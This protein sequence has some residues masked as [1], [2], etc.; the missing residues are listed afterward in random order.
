MRSPP[1]DLTTA[2]GA[3]LHYAEFRDIEEG[4]DFGTI[5]VL[6]AA[7]SSEIAVIADNIDGVTSDWEQAREALPPEALGKVIR[8]EFRFTSDDISNFAGWYIDDPQV[9]VP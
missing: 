2:G 5:R 9:T 6:D 4:F 7:D 3:T 8:I 1:I